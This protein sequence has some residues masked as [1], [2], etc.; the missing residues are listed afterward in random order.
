M[1]PNVGTICETDLKSSSI[2]NATIDIAVG[3]LANIIGR[4]NSTP[5]ITQEVI[6]GSGE[7]ITP[8]QYT[9]NGDVQE[10]VTFCFPL[11]DVTY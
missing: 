1:L 3:D 6:F 9:G 10:W 7:P 11:R 4:L 8:N 5:Y 2:D